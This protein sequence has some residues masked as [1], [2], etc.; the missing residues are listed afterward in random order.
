MRLSISINAFVSISKEVG[1]VTNV[2]GSEDDKRRIIMIF[3]YIYI[4]IYLIR[5]IFCDYCC[6][7]MAISRIS[8]I[9]A[10]SAKIC[11]HAKK[12]QPKVHAN[13]QKKIQEH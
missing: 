4:F 1:V 11:V 12:C 3:I 2:D 5:I 8:Q 10:E 9:F 6:S 7:S 13:F